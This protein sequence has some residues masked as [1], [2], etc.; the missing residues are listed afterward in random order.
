MVVKTPFVGGG[1]GGKAPVQLEILAY[2]ASRVVGG[3]LVKLANSREEDIVT[4]PCRLGL[5]ARIKLGAS[6]SGFLKAAEMTFLV[7]TGAYT[8]IG[9]RLSKSIAIC[10][11][12]HIL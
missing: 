5:E 4:S 12:D 10:C 11:T 8:D 2:M 1:F 7:D 3:K 6:R 9:P